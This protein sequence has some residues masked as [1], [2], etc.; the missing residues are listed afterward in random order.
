MR[1]GYAARSSPVCPARGVHKGQVAKRPLCP[2][3]R[4]VAA[5]GRDDGL[6][7]GADEGDVAVAG[8]PLRRG[9]RDRLREEAPV[10]LRARQA[11]L[12]MRVF[13]SVHWC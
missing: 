11:R 9:R 13:T 12:Y 1:N 7:V 3:T 8:G 6:A 4:K 10:L 2:A 5:Q